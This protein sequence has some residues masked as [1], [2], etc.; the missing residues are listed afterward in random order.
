MAI[1]SP[2][3]LLETSKR[4]YKQ[5][6]DKLT[7]RINEAFGRVILQPDQTS[8]QINIDKPV[9]NLNVGE[10]QVLIKKLLASAGYSESDVVVPYSSH[11]ISIT[12]T[13][14]PQ[15]E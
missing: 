7:T 12:V 5:V 6:T 14:P 2:T 1:I 3:Q 4:N 10:V 13:I 9:C 11:Q 8:V 15:G